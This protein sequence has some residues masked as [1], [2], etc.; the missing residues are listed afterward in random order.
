MKKFNRFYA[1]IAVCAAM[2][3]WGISFVWTKQLLNNGFNVIFIVTTRLIVSFLLLFLIFKF[4]KRLEK[5]KKQDIPKFLFL[6][7]FEPFLYFIGENYGLKYVD[8]SFAA[9]FIAIIPVVIPLGLRLFCYEKINNSIIIGVI[10]SIIGI[11]IMSVGNSFSFN[12]DIKGILLLSLAVLSAAGYS[13]MLS[14]LLNYNPVTITV[15]QNL[16]AFVYYLPLLCITNFKSVIN[17]TA[18]TMQWNFESFFAL[19]MLSVFCSSIAFIGYSYAAKHISIAKAS[20]FT[21]TIPV[22]TIAFAVLIGQEHIT[23][24][25]IVG[26]FIVIGGVFCSQFMIKKK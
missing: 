8:A 19:V 3:F 9:I 5:V 13:I 10:I 4:T 24:N 21:N 16:I 15:Y 18:L 7:F 17:N 14:K 26:I 20:V 22:I 12:V 2:F 11:I 1:Y 23:I 25:K 6:A